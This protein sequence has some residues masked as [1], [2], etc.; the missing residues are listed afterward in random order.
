MRPA[1]PAC[2]L[3]AAEIVI[4]TSS[5]PKEGSVNR[6]PPQRDGWGIPSRRPRV[7]SRPGEAAAPS[8]HGRSERLDRR[9]VREE[10][11]AIPAVAM[12]R[13]RPATADRGAGPIRRHD[14]GH[15]V[16]RAT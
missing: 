11:D 4:G 9:L 10:A 8:G 16:V 5:Q 1:W 13:H 6:T 2:M 12:A 7:A 15:P 14:T 3:E